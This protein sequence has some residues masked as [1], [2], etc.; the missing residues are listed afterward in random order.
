[1]STI[2]INDYKRAYNIGVK[3]AKRCGYTSWYTPV[4]GAAYNL[5]YEGYTIDFDTVVTA[6]RYGELPE[7]SNVSFN[8]RENTK[9]LGVSVACLKGEE[10]VGSCMFFQDRQKVEVKGLLVSAK[11]SDGEPLILPLGVDQWDF[12]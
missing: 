5:G 7:G 6:E 4:L 1:M 11:G 10:E 12:E 2:T 8:Y 9:E 3:D